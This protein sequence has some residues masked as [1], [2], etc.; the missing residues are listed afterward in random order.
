MEIVTTVSVDP[1]ST[2]GI[3]GVG[4]CRYWLIGAWSKS[5]SC[6]VDF[7]GF[8]TSRLDRFQCTT[9]GALVLMSVCE[10]TFGSNVISITSS[11]TN[12]DN[13]DKWVHL[14]VSTV[15]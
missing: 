1:T 3:K 6:F 14:Y 10:C 15:Y 4:C 12:I 5:K 7:K 8:I 13:I 2:L 9:W 11:I